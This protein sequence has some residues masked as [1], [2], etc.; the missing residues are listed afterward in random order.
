M[1]LEPLSEQE[2][3]RMR[4]I[5]DKLGK[6]LYSILDFWWRMFIMMMKTV[7]MMVISSKQRSRP[8]GKWE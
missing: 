6:G 7:T 2:Y 1:K 4:Q 5:M 3:T 8:D